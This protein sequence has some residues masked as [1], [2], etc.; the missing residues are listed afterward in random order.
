MS[1]NILFVLILLGILCLPSVVSAQGV[2]GDATISQHRPATFGEFLAAE[3]RGVAEARCTNGAMGADPYISNGTTTQSSANF[4]ISGTGTA[5]ILNV[6]TQ[7]NA[8]GLRAFMIGFANSSGFGG[9]HTFA[10]IGAGASNYSDTIGNS[11]FGAEAGEDNTSGGVNSFFGYA[12]G[13][14]N[15]TGSANSFFGKQS[16]GKTTVGFGNSIFGS[17]AGYANVSGD[18]NTAIG[19]DADFAPE[20]VK[21]DRIGVVLINAIKEQQAQI[22][23]QKG[24]IE[25]QQK[26]LLQQQTMIEILKITIC[27]INPKATVCGGAK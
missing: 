4:N 19:A 21:Y 18:Y 14:K 16:G 7:L 11:F 13:E 3:P 27:Q 2:G 6:E 26:Q 25:D 24:K 9:G 1:R 8:R 17:G 23:T 10:G 20:G 12:S 15:T 22:E 5:N